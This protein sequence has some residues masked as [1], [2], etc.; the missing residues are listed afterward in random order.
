MAGEETRR[1]NVLCI[2]TDQQ[3]ADHLG[4]AGNPLI[5]TPNVDRLAASGARFERAYVHNPICS[6]SRSTMWTGLSVRGH[7][8]RG[9]GMPLD[10]RIPTVPSALAEAGYRTHGVGKFHLTPTVALNGA[11]PRSLNPAEWPEAREMWES[12][13]VGALATPYYGLQS[14]L[15]VGGHGEWFWGDYKRW[16]LHEAPEVIKAI[17]DYKRDYG[18]NWRETRRSFIPAEL[19]HS[20]WIADRVIESLREQSQTQQP[21]FCWCSFPDPHHPYLAPDPYFSMYGPDD[22]P[23]PARREGELD[24]LPPHYR[25]VQNTSRA[26]EG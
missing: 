9:C 3:R 6:P 16:L 7:R 4:C 11:D 2:V 20:H 13:L 8:V 17:S 12:G 18:A 22:M 5:Q 1:P 26:V 15:L 25:I 19:H 24:D 14:A 10:R 21:F 23:T